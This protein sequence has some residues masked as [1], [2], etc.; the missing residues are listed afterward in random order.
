M[1]HANVTIKDTCLHG[2]KDGKVLHVQEFENTPG[3]LWYWVVVPSVHPTVGFWYK[4]N[5]LTIKLG[6]LPTYDKT[7]LFRHKIEK[8]GNVA[9]FRIDRATK[10]VLIAEGYTVTYDP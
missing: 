7:K 3:I 8:G 2:G 9:R 1:S 5:C 10:D 4:E 6:K